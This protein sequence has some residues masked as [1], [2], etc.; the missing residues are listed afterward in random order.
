MNSKGEAV[1]MDAERL[2]ATIH[3][4]LET[5]S[6]TQHRLARQKALLQEHATRLRLGASPTAVRVALHEAAALETGDLPASEMGW[7]PNPRLEK[8]HA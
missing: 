8:A 5:I 6:G 2:L 1:T 4:E 3:R 7:E